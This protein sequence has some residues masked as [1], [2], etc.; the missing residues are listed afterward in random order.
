V[1]SVSRGV[2]CRAQPAKPALAKRMVPRQQ[3]R[4]NSLCLS[5]SSWQAVY[6]TLTTTV[7]ETGCRTWKRISRRAG[8]NFPRFS[9]RRSSLE[10]EKSITALSQADRPKKSMLTASSPHS[11]SLDYHKK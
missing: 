8:P 6:E 9:L 1:S 2:V 11:I 5:S 4:K 10:T 3:G 7:T